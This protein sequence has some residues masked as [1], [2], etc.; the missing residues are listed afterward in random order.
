M[1]VA[2]TYRKMYCDIQEGLRCQTQLS[3]KTFISSQIQNLC[4]MLLNTAD[5][6][7]P[8]NFTIAKYSL[9]QMAVSLSYL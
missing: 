7:L 8:E 4:K 9:Q 2:Q 5:P 1:F 6:R 3:I